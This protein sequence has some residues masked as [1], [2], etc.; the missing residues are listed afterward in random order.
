MADHAVAV[1]PVRLQ[2]IS[3]PEAARLRHAVALDLQVI[4]ILDQ[5]VLL[6]RSFPD[7]RF[8]LNDHLRDRYLEPRRL[9]HPRDQSLLTVRHL[10]CIASDV[11]ILDRSRGCG[12]ADRLRIPRALLIAM[13][14]QIR[15]KLGYHVHVA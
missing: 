2:N 7:R 8:R 13:A 3:D 6:D 5:P 15:F 4:W 1:Q 11:V 10:G 9:E 12:L 14:S